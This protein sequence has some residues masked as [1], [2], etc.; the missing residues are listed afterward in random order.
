MPVT[1]R[2]SNGAGDP[3]APD[4]VPD[5]RGLAVEVLP[6]GRQRAPTSSPRPRRGFPSARRRRSSS[7][8][9]AQEREPAM[10]WRL[11]AFLARHPEAI[12]ALPANREPCAAARELRH[13]PLL[14]ASTPSASSTRDG[15]SRYVRYTFIPERGEPRLSPREARGRGRDY[16][17]D[18]I[19]A[20]VAAAA[21]PLHARAADRRARGHRRRSRQAWPRRRQRVDARHARAHRARDRTGDRRR[22]PRVRPRAGDRRA[23]SSPTT[24]SCATGP[25]AYSDSVPKKR[26]DGRA[27]PRPTS[28]PER[29][30]GRRHRGQQRARADRLRASWRAPGA[31]GHRL[32]RHREGRA[33][34]R[35]R[36]APRSPAPS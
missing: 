30:H 2:V 6:A 21:G 7:C 19:R 28:R 22:C 1:V 29:P 20:R 11:P 15:G 24:P 16:L 36:S 18:E 23:S 35:A 17:Q 31:R 8:L 34:S 33:G 14:R 10:A 26:A 3:D 25:S 32:P 27:G 12:G 13:V 5:V 9:R 4:Y